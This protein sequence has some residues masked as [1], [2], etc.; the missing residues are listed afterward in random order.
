MITALQFG[1][2]VDHHKKHDVITWSSIGSMISYGIG[3]VIYFSSD[4]SVFAHP[5]S[6]QLW[7]LIIVL[8]SGSII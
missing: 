5:T 7:L 2:I 3:A 4:A 6:R 8:M 1:N